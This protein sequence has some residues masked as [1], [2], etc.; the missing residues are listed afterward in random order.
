[1]TWWTLPSPWD[2]ILSILAVVV[3][4]GSLILLM[5]SS[6]YGKLIYAL[7][8]FFILIIPVASL[9]F[10]TLFLL[11]FAPIISLVLA[12]SFLTFGGYGVVWSWKQ[13][14]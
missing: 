6:A 1:M 2:W 5:G 4:H 10:F 12:I 3:F 7:L 11:P 14:S 9:S 13:V 8:L